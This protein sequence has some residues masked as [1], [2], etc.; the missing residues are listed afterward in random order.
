[1]VGGASISALG[2]AGIYAG[3]RK[4]TPRELQFD[5]LNRSGDG[6][7]E[8]WAHPI[9]NLIE[10]SVPVTQFSTELISDENRAWIINYANEKGIREI[11]EVYGKVNLFRVNDRIQYRYRVVPEPERR[12]ADQYKSYCEFA[13]YFLF[14]QQQLPSLPRIPLRWLFP[15][16]D[17]PTD[18]VPAYIGHSFIHEQKIGLEFK[19][20]DGT[21]INAE[22]VYPEPRSGGTMLGAAWNFDSETGEL[23][24]S[25]W[26]PCIIVST[27]NELSLQAPFSEVTPL[28]F[29]EGIGKYVRQLAESNPLP[30]SIERKK[31]ILNQSMKIAETISESVSIYLTTALLHHP[32]M[33]EAKRRISVKQIEEWGLGLAVTDKQKYAD[34]PKAYGYIKRHGLEQTIHLFTDDPTLYLQKIREV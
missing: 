10:K 22:V 29:A 34:V 21:K 16:E 20:H 27:Y 15:H 19:L 1:M 14:E 12:Y 30:N 24:K 7:L 6:S 3:V 5:F 28:M 25:T 2:V 8:Q 18:A 11:E 33:R 31:E 13:T 23:K 32:T 17:K 9:R 26:H 4:S